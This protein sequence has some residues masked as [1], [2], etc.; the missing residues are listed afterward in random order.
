[1]N[2]VAV[3][4]LHD[5]D[6]EVTLNAVN[7]LTSYG[8]KQ[9]EEPL[10]R[11]YV[12]WTQRWKGKEPDFDGMRTAPTPDVSDRLIGEELGRSL[13]ANQGW[14]ADADLIARVM[15]LCDGMETCRRIGSNGAGSAKPPYELSL[16]NPA[17]LFH[18]GMPNSYGVAQY[19]TR[20]FD[21]F[22]AKIAQYPPGTKFVLR[23]GGRH[24]SD[25]QKLEAR[26]HATLEKHGM[27]LEKPIN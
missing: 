10:W 18:P 7:Y 26:V 22:E 8:R 16:P 27:V 17:R 20:S 5:P 11:R 1:L 15:K 25:M 14:L 23:P 2:D 13:I 9:D 6:P 3:E 19:A 12:E 4:A 21:L 24:N